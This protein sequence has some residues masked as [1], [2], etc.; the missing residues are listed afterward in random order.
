MDDGDSQTGDFPFGQF[1][2]DERIE[3][4]VEG[5]IMHSENHFEEW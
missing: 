1:M 4:M 3:L 5:R 2:T